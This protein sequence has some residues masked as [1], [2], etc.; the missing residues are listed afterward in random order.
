MRTPHIIDEHSIVKS[1]WIAKDFAQFF[2]AWHVFYN[3]YL[4]WFLSSHVLQKLVEKIDV[5]Q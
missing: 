4:P 5:Q 3:Q 1:G 2:K